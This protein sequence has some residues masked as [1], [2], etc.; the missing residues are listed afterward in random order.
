M[1]SLQRSVGA[2]VRES[3]GGRESDALRSTRPIDFLMISPGD[4]RTAQL[5]LIQ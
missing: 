2:A 4:R 1:R 3:R 5:S